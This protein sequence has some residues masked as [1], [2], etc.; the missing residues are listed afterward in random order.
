MSEGPDLLDTHGRLD[1]FWGMSAETK[2]DPEMQQ[3]E[4]L[5]L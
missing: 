1:K 4:Y 5:L 2:S 3:D